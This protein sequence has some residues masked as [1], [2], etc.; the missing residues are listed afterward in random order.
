M[1]ELAVEEDEISLLET[2]YWESRKVRIEVLECEARALEQLA[3]T[4]QR[5]QRRK[6]A[7]EDT[8]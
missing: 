3:E 1:R 8:D 7:G 5:K 6:P 2:Y 4:I